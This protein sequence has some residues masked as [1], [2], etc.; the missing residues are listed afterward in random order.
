MDLRPPRSTRTDT[1]VPY[2]RHFGVTRGSDAPRPICF[3]TSAA[4]RR[5]AW[6]R[7]C[8]LEGI[9]AADALR[10]RG[11]SRLRAE[12]L[13]LVRPAEGG[14]RRGP[15]LVRHSIREDLDRP[16]CS[17]DEDRARHD[18]EASSAAARPSGVAL[19]HWDGVRNPPRRRSRLLFLN[20]R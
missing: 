13:P 5:R 2:T 9:S 12:I 1:L 14:F 7:N 15:Y 10:R 16:Q 4:A 19:V 3:G 18:R 11:R 20:Q 6:P 8:A 17:R